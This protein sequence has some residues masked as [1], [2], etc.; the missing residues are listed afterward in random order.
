MADF[1]QPGV[2]VRDVRPLLADA[3]TLAC[4]IDA[5]GLIFG[6]ALAQRLCAGFVPLSKPGARTL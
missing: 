1:P 5:R 3:A 4:G 2:I 6:A